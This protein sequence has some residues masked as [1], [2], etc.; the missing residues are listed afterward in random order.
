MHIHDM[1]MPETFCHCGVVRMI[2]II[3]VEYSVQR[4]HFGGGPAVAVSWPPFF[5]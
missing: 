2:N 3:I 5:Q 4:L 1:N